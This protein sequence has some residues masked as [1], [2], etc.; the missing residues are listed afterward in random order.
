MDS[1]EILREHYRKIRKEITEE[2][3]EEARD[4]AAKKLYERIGEAKRVLSFASKEEEIDLWPL[5]DKLAKENRLLLPHLGTDANIAPY[6]VAE[7]DT[8]LIMQEKWHVLEPDPKRCPRVAVEEV[9]II[10]VPGLAF[11]R[12]HGRLGYGK[13]HYDRFLMHLS[14]LLI[15]VGFKEQLLEEPFLHEK[16][17]I[18]LTEIY[19]F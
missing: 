12:G 15:G 3:R 1:K 13:G 7:L 4:E 18:P 17:D 5:N 16:H 14:C 11:D 9:E 19:L 10:I 8:Q 6:L 2:R